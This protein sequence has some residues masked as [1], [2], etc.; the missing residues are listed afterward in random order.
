[1]MGGVQKCVCIH[2]NLFLQEFVCW[3]GVPLPLTFARQKAR[4][5]T[6]FK[7]DTLKEN[8]T[9]DNR[10]IIHP[11]TCLSAGDSCIKFGVYGV[12]DFYRRCTSVSLGFGLPDADYVSVQ[13]GEKTEPTHITNCSFLLD[14][15]SSQRLCF[16]KGILD[17]VHQNVKG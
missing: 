2:T 10:I 13:I 4:S 9:F 7:M 1:M 5:G 8:S 6:S 14:Q 15:F 17:A 11:P 3:P 16:G 12:K